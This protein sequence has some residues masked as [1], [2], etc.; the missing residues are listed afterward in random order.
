MHLRAPPP[1]SAAQTQASRS[2]AGWTM[3]AGRIGSIPRSCIRRAP[4]AR[5]RA[6]C[7][8]ARAEVVQRL[9]RN[10]MACSASCHRFQLAAA[11]SEQ[12]L[13]VFDDEKKCGSGLCQSAGILSSVLASLMS[14][15]SSY[16][17]P[18]CG[19]TSVRGQCHR[20]DRQRVEEDQLPPSRVEPRMCEQLLSLIIS[21]SPTSSA[22]CLIST[23]CTGPSRHY[24]SV[25][26]RR[27]CGCQWKP[28]SS[29]CGSPR[30]VTKF[31]AGGEEPA[32]GHAQARTAFLCARSNA[33]MV[34]WS[35][36]ALVVTDFI[37]PISLGMS[38]A[39]GSDLR[40]FHVRP[41][42]SKNL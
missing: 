38:F 30:P 35:P 18:M 42:W 23:R 15:P 34:F 11:R 26:A 7:L 28:F 12:K 4:C 27:G 32:R 13:R 25:Q 37:Q 17:S 22:H 29:G 16:H 21:E 8:R 41:Y 19:V 14:P 1:P 31:R 6:R 2:G 39:L 33:P 36:Q 24:P 5:N 9:L 10:P 20:F 3:T 40:S